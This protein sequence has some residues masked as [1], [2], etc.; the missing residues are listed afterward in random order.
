MLKWS[1]VAGEL[2]R[3]VDALRTSASAGAAATATEDRGTDL[4][5]MLQDREYQ[6]V[7]GDTFRHHVSLFE[8]AEGFSS[9][10]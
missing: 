3:K 2:E 9:L 8:L 10:G 6:M 5:P 7:F 4:L 1:R